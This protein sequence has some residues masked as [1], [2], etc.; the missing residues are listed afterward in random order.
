MRS[1]NYCT[2]RRTIRF[3]LID[4]MKS[5]ID[6]CKT[7]R[8]VLMIKFHGRVGLDTN[9]QVAKIGDGVKDINRTLQRKG[10]K[11]L[12]IHPFEIISS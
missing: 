11:E 5:R 4:D 9:Q 8:N 7:R 3:Q 2:I 10:D 12:G 6:E 1:L